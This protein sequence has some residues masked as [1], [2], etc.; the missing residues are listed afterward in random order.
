MAKGPA[1]LVSAKAKDGRSIVAGRQVTGFTNAEEEAAKLTG[2]VPFLL[3]TRLRE[4]G[5][6]YVGGEMWKSHA[7]RDGNLVTGQNP[8]SSER[9]ARLVLASI[10]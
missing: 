10:A 6:L 5:G 4:L 1:G 2:I 3:E 9:V 8:A 7:V